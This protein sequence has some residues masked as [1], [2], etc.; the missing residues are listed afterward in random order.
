MP[1]LATEVSKEK[2]WR[3]LDPEEKE[4]L[5]KGV[6][7]R[8]NAKGPVHQPVDANAVV[9]SFSSNLNTEVSFN[10]ISPRHSTL[11]L[12]ILLTKINTVASNTG[13][14]TFYAIVRGKSSDTFS[15]RVTAS[16]QVNAAFTVLFKQSF[17]SMAL[18]VDAYIVAG[19]AGALRLSAGDKAD[20]TRKEIRSYINKGLGACIFLLPT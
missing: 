3:T 6:Q 15:A 16:P 11:N 12:S 8:K 14:H 2:E 20:R 5:L 19:L 1:A 4:W 13:A 7:E 10:F 18:K 9:E 17:E